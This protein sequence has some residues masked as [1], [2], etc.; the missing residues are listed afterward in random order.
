MVISN[1]ATEQD[2]ANIKRNAEDLQKFVNGTEP[3]QNQ[4]GDTL[5]PIPVVNSTY[6]V[7]QAPQDG[8]AYGRKDGAWFQLP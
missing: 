4:S 1:P 2:I 6:V 3:F 7:E 8:N 5:I